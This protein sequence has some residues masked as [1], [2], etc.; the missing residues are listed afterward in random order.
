MECSKC[1]V[2]E[3]SY[4]L[5]ELR[6]EDAR[7]YRTCK[8]VEC[9]LE[10]SRMQKLDTDTDRFSSLK[11]DSSLSELNCVGC[12]SVFSSDRSY[13]TRSPR[14]L[15]ND[16]SMLLDAHGRVADTNI[17]ART[18]V[19]NK[20]RSRKYAEIALNYTT[21]KLCSHIYDILLLLSKHAGYVKIKYDKTLHYLR[22]FKNNFIVYL[23]QC[24]LV[25]ITRH[26]QNAAK[27]IQNLR[28]ASDILLTNE[29]SLSLA[30]SPTGVSRM[31]ANVR[32]SAKL[33]TREQPRQS[34]C[35]HLSGS[36]PARWQILILCSG[37]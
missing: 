5:K 8:Q 31:L 27:F 1:D 23:L 16:R 6:Y 12:V 28:I 37:E 29:A 4:K 7:M 19:M 22:G 30:E 11:L 14:L 20:K 9:S 2:F 18:H 21:H 17:V 25:E 33:S 10:R 13:M 35:R 24:V 36:G 32:D 26:A 34:S 3:T 15:I